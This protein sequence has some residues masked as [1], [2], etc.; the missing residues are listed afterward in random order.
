MSRVFVGR[1][2][3]YD[4]GLNVRGY[5][6][7]FRTGHVDSAGEFDGDMATS[8]VLLN[9]F[10]EIGVHRIVGQHPAYVNFTRA[11]LLNPDLELPREQLVLEV[12]EDTEVDDD[13]LSGV[14]RLSAQGYRIALDDVTADERW[15]PLLELAD[16]IKI[17]VPEVPREEVPAVVERL[18]RHGVVL[19][20]EKIES[21]EDYELYRDLGVDLF[22]GFAFGRPRVVEGHGI[23]AN[24]Q[25]L[26]GLVAKVNDPDVEFGDIEDLIAQDPGLSFKLLR[27]LNSSY[28]GLRQPISSIR[29]AITY[30]GLSA[31]R[32]W[33]TIIALA[34][35]DFV[36]HDLLGTSLQRA[37][38]C[39]L[40]ST[41]VNPDAEERAFTCGLLSLVDAVLDRPMD[42]VLEGMGLSE[43]LRQALT[44]RDGQLGQ[45]LRIAEACEMG[46][47]ATVSATIRV[48]GLDDLNVEALYLEAI[49]WADN[50]SQD[51][52]AGTATT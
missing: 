7:L 6:I 40:I 26:M 12:L 46:D 38:L 22:Q 25:V 8:Q 13:L 36:P 11:L 31:V 18:G 44:H 23:G 43:E 41:H 42:E 21:F 27:Y 51:L 19:L 33:V 45:L 9:T 34:G 52:L 10:L 1:Q 37:R 48:L 24:Q 50:A 39:R 35:V 5:E 20:A 4:G 17:D 14:A 32:T 2:P 47:L 49:E 30:L 16:V 15:A 3:I 28:F 29:Q